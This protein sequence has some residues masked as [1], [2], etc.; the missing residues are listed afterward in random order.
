[1]DFNNN[2]LIQA[3]KDAINKAF[4]LK[5][6]VD[7]ESKL[8]QETESTENGENGE[9]TID[10]KNT[11]VWVEGYK[12]T[13]RDMKCQG[14][15]YELGT[16]YQM[17]REKVSECSTGYHLCLNMDDVQQYYPI[18]G[19]NR[20]FKVR[21]LVRLSDRNEYGKSPE[22]DSSDYYRWLIKP[23]TPRNKL[24]AAEI[25][26]L[27]ELTVDEILSDTRAKY[28]SDD[29]KK[30]AIE[31]SIKAAETEMLTTEL[32]ELGYS[33]PFASYLVNHKKFDIAKAVGS[34]E[35][36]SMDMKV[37]MIMQG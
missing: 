7:M 1:M 20:Y 21:A 32:T 5:T 17:P 34:Q 13:D 2:E 15:Q 27:E 31:I 16:T 9:N 3:A 25:E 30:L 14:F 24:V 23:T 4:G 35:D 33:L 12:G 8:K 22:V 11:W 36:L 6:E 28:W 19:G 10:V 26:F 18:G 29:Y 37:L